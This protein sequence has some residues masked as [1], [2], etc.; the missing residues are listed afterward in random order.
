[1]VLPS[2]LILQYKYILSLEEKIVWLLVRTENM[3]TGNMTKMASVMINVY[4]NYHQC[5]K[6]NILGNYF[7]LRN[8]TTSLFV[9]E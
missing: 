4:T 2:L 6:V 1:M 3:G 9:S 8:L 7:W 5:N